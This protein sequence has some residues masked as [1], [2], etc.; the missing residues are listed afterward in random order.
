[1]AIFPCLGRVQCFCVVSI[2][3][4]PACPSRT[5]LM[6]TCVSSSTPWS[7]TNRRMWPRSWTGPH[8]R[9]P[10]NWRTSAHA[11]LS[12][13]QLA[14]AEML[15]APL[16]AL[17]GTFGRRNVYFFSP[18]FQIL[19]WSSW[20]MFQSNMTP[21]N[22]VSALRFPNTSHCLCEDSCH[23]SFWPEQFSS[24]KCPRQDAS[25]PSAPS[26]CLPFWMEESQDVLLKFL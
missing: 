6:E 9:C 11:T 14:R 1:M 16:G 13:R 19:V 22:T 15:A 26:P 17:P 5:W 21:V 4:S 2:Q 8:P 18:P 20:F 10:R 12:E 23:S 25:W 24:G 7:R 3:F